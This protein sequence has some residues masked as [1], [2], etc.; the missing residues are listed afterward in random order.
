MLDFVKDKSGSGAGFL[1]ELRFP[2]PI[3]IP[4]ASPQ[5]SSLSPEAGTIGQECL[6][7]QIKNKI[8]IMFTY[9]RYSIAKITVWH[10]DRLLSGDSV[11]KVRFWVTV[12]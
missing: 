5:S 7:N 3:Y 1:P 2:L 10:T 4:S 9:G 11:N 6:T 8:K 12:R